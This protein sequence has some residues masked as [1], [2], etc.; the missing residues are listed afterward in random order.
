[1]RY[2][3]KTGK[4]TEQR[5]DVAIVPVYDGGKL[6]TAARAIDS[7]ISG[8]ISAVNKSADLR[9][10]VGQTLL[11]TQTEGCP[12][13]RLLL[14]GCGP[15][16]EFDGRAYRKAMRAAF[17]A[18]SGSNHT[19]AISYVSLERVAGSDAYR[20]ARIAV[21]TW[22]DTV[23]RFTAMKSN[24]K[25]D[26]PALKTLGIAVRDRKAATRAR[27]GIAHG[28]AIG[29][30][31]DLTR[32]LGNLPANVCTPTYLV[33]RTR[34]LAKNAPK[35]TVQ[36]LNE[37]EMRKLKMG[38]LLSV[39]AGT[40]EPA[41]FIVLRYRGA[42]AA[43]PPIALIGKGIT[44]D[45]GGISLKPPGAMDEM[46]FDMSGA[47]TVVGVMKAITQLKLK[48]NLVGLVPAAEN[49]P[50]GKATKPGD[51]VT[52]MSGQTIEV[53]NTDAEGRLIL[54]DSLTYAQRFKPAAMID[55]ATLTGSCVVALGKHRTGLL[56]NSNRLA[57]KL[58]DAGN[59]ADDPAWQ[60]PLDDE[61]QAQLKS[62]FA[63]VANVGG[64]DAGTITAACFL[65]RFVDGTDWA[66]LDIAGTA[67]RGGARKGST[68]RPVPLLVEFLLD[69]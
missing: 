32:D 18:L 6:G 9:D 46:K 45:A 36:V 27:R 69:Q 11:L 56:S 67:W 30:G 55:V 49:L 53:L 20:L 42:A 1:M 41:K 40:D 48:V 21:E 26:K 7:V 2:Q 62:N 52:S 23:Y 51:I 38:A 66:H 8:A 60:L 12:F 4:P 35:L 22:H 65:S 10:G 44:F 28:D 14:V 68:G 50:S 54:S 31:Q 33:K 57:K 47:A 25:V 29:A 16:D 59:A 63:D 15:K 3:V 19:D 43:K 64:R 17:T 39:T 24:S 58:L 13:D 37:A 61:Y 5:A 34:E